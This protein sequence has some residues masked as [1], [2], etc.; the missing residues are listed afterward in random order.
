MARIGVLAGTFMMEKSSLLHGGKKEKVRTPYGEAC[1]VITDR[2]V[3]VL[4][5]GAD[6]NHY[7]LPHLINHPANL[8]ALKDLGATEVIGVNSTGSLKKNLSPGLLVIPDDFISFAPTPTVAEG[9]PLHI[10][11]SLSENVRGRLIAAAHSAGIAAAEKGVYWQVPGP[12]LE[13]RTEIRMMSAF[14]DVVGMTMASEAAVASEL[15]L[16]YASACSIDNYGNGL[17]EKPL[18]MEQII[19]GTRRNADMMKKLLESYLLVTAQA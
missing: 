9:R 10:A 15:D 2:L 13:T 19:A 11:P 17:V 4:R 5:H 8:R 7:V 18:R 6:P 12:R 1:A 16:P 3:F 14:A